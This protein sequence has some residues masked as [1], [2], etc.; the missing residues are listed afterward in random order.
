V[1]EKKAKPPRRRRRWLRWMGRLILISLVT[2]TTLLY[3]AWRER[4]LLINAG[5]LRVG[6]DFRLQIEALEWENGV[7]RVKG[8][9]VIHG[10][11]AQRIADVGG[12]EWQPVWLQLRMKNVGTLKVSG[13]VLDLPLSLFSDEGGSDGGGDGALPWR[14]ENV[15]FGPTRF[16]LR[17][18]AH[19]ILVSGDLEGRIEDGTNVSLEAS[20]LHWKDH[21]VIRRLKGSASMKGGRGVL[22][23][24]LIEGG[25]VDLSWLPLPVP[26]QGGFEL[27]WQGKGVEFSDGEMVA[28]GTH[29]VRLKNV[30]V[31][32]R[33]GPGR[34]SLAQVNLDFAQESD[35]LWRLSEGMLS[36]PEIDWTRELEE[37]LVP[38]DKTDQEQKPPPTWKA[39]VDKLEVKDGRI[40]VAASKMLPVTGDLTWEASFDG[41]KISPEGIRSAMKQ[42]LKVWELELRWQRP[43]TD[44]PLPFASAEAIEL[45]MVP[46]AWRDAL[47]VESMLM[48]KPLVWLTPEN[49][50]W[51]DQMTEAPA[52]AAAT[53]ELPLWKRASFGR[54]TLSE[55]R[56]TVAANLAERVELS[57]EVDISTEGP[58]QRLRLTNVRALVPKRA[59]LPVLALDTVEA[60]ATLPDMWR[61]RRLD[62][63]E[64][65]G[66][67]IE[68][69][70]A[71][72]T[73]FSG[74]AEKVEKKIDE[75]AERWTAATADVKGVGVTIMSLA[76][77]LPP[78][79]FDLAFTAKETPLDLDGLAENVEPQRVVLTH[80]RI[81][82]PYE[83][84]RTVAEMGVIHVDYTLDGLLHRRIDK[85]E[86][87]APLLYV[88][89]D[90]FWYVES[91]RKFMDAEPPKVDPSLGPPP[92][93]K[94]KAPGWRVDVLAVSD[95]RLILAPKG[96][97][98][99]GFG[100]PF[101][102]SFA[103]VLDSGQ[104]E[105]EFDI[106]S[107]DYILKD[108]KLEFRGMKGNVQFN[109]PLKERNNNLTE[110][111]TV[112]QIR[113]KSLHLEK[114]HLSVTY[115]TV[116][117]YGQFGGQAYGGYV[118][119][120]FD[121]YL[122]E[123]FTWDGWVTGV[124]V[125]LGP[126]TQALFPGYFLLQGKAEAKLIATG[127]KNELY[128]GDAEF[129]NRSPGK[130]SIKA[131]N[132]MI[133]KLPPVKKGDI[134]DQIMR[135]GLETLRD[136]EYDSVNGK[137]RMYGREGS[138]YLR[139]AGPHGTR[140]IDINVLDH[141]WKA[142]P[143]RAEPDGS[144]Q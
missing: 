126:V 124:D 30:V 118:N 7:M 133:E 83:P 94:P 129:T 11:S 50:P 61:L 100:Q 14:V 69:G 18:D 78:V 10:P 97:P 85:V 21:L 53:P 74:D 132:D 88:G 80:L 141:R 35:G 20:Q 84:L 43:G 137:A 25:R 44:L 22:K 33:T 116:G 142:E 13:A 26:L 40:N 32:P 134:A 87:V 5:L 139:F 1:L 71:L 54:L 15:E 52:Q 72:M 6:G 109:L 19:E 31:E 135:I 49:G 110:T 12:I 39:Q 3:F 65:N 96:V 28:G 144:D 4:V 99:P 17:D 34:V 140:K 79:R 75:V 130:F 8:A 136:F 95:G 143:K 24:V 119:G 91:Y 38:G 98:L 120:A 73:L 16:I 101:P 29:E 62:V 92:P 90:L 27:E 36:K 46:D 70:D 93:E 2:G 82:S 59:N 112:E 131:L 117:I 57:T 47:R 113:W 66:G 58:Q 81:P 56:L 55:G 9:S 45:V 89:E 138:G 86:I 115:D 122:D 63:L 128:Q 114:A 107:D 123:V 41:L 111:F 42:R 102:F 60:A 64:L 103:T 105:A 48:T 121:F 108:L 68:V 51:F 23:D 76:P 37:A 104:L 77:G 127:N 125:D 106:P 67:Q